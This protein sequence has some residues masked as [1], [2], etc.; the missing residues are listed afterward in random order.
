M[1]IQLR[2]LPRRASYRNRSGVDSFRSPVNEIARLEYAAPANRMRRIHD[3]TPVVRG[4]PPIGRAAYDIHREFREGAV[5][6]AGRW[7]IL[8]AGKE[9]AESRCASISTSSTTS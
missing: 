6:V 4:E 9:S 3:G 8:S 7:G 2:L 1:A 5:I